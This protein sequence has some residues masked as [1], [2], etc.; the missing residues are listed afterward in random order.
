MGGAPTTQRGGRRRPGGAL[1]DRWRARTTT[2]RRPPGRWATTPG[3]PG[4]G[5]GGSAIPTR[6]ILIVDLT[7][8]S[9]RASVPRVAAARCRWP[10]SGGRPTANLWRRRLRRAGT[11][12]SGGRV[13]ASTV[14][15]WQSRH[16]LQFLVRRD[17]RDRIPTGLH[18]LPVVA[19]RA[20]G[21]GRHLLLRLR[22]DA[23]LEGQP[24][25]PPFILYLLSGSSPT[26][27]STGRSARRTGAL[28]GQRD[29]ITTMRVPGNL[30]DRQGD[31]PVREFSAVLPILLFVAVVT[32]ADLLSVDLLDRAGGAAAGDLPHRGGAAAVGDQRDDAR[33]VERFMR[34]IQRMIFYG[35]PIIYCPGVGSK[36][37]PELGDGASTTPTRSSPSSSCTT[38]PGIRR[39]SP[40]RAPRLRDRGCL[41]TLLA[42]SARYLRRLESAVLK[43][44]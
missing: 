12:R 28:T 18:G 35:S 25:G 17:P 22:S 3:R 4:R 5:H 43:E 23:R 20:V 13:A 31:R 29:L 33:D 44:L 34:L 15:V 41:L 40:P 2:G 8:L 38:P 42:G 26:C 9:R 27:G 16:V 21:H 1:P 11:R 6:A 7:A 37:V 14:S 30:P 39:C 10:R 19:D 32:G 24:R 36:S